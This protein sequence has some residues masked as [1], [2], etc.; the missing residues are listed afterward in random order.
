MSCLLMAT[1]ITTTLPSSLSVGSTSAVSSISLTVPFCRRSRLRGQDI[2]DRQRLVAIL[3]SQLLGPV[4]KAHAVVGHVQI[5]FPVALRIGDAEQGLAFLHG[6]ASSRFFRS[7]VTIWPSIGL[8]TSR[9]ATLASMILAWALRLISFCSRFGQLAHQPR[10]VLGLQRVP[11]AAQFVPEVVE[12]LASRWP[13]GPSISSFCAFK[14]GI[15]ELQQELA[16]LDPGA[17]FDRLA[18][19]V[20][21]EFSRPGLRRGVDVLAIDRLQRSL[22]VQ[23]EVGRHR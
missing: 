19:D 1:L 18:L 23:V 20:L 21:P 22:G 15:A 11:L 3:G 2:G 14:R 16:L 10:M 12:V 6:P 8:C 7:E 17:V 4:D 5:E 13:P 9:S